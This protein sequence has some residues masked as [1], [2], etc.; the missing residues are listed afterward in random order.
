[1]ICKYKFKLCFDSENEDPGMLRA[2][3]ESRH[4]VVKM[5]PIRLPS[6]DPK[7]EIRLGLHDVLAIANLDN[8]L[9]DMRTAHIHGLNIHP[10][11]SQIP[12]LAIFSHSS[13]GDDLEDFM[14]LVENYTIFQ[15]SLQILKSLQTLVFCCESRKRPTSVKRDCFLNYAT[16]FDL[17]ALNATQFRLLVAAR[18]SQLLYT[19]LMNDW[20]LK[21]KHDDLR[22]PEIKIMAKGWPAK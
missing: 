19:E 1:M 17:S 16:N 12:A 10:S 9:D 6:S 21:E 22:I 13:F 11:I 7:K 18:N 4:V 2:C 8:F 15:R 3:K 20:R 14:N 5:L